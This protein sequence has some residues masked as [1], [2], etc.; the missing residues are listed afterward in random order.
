MLSN[1]DD[2]VERYVAVWNE[3]DPALRR[4]GVSE[5]WADD[6]VYANQ[7]AEFRGHAGIEAAVTEAYEQFVKNGEYVFKTA[8]VD[9]NHEAVRFTWDMVPTAG[10]EP[11]SI[12]TQLFLVGEDGR[13]VHDYQFIDKMPS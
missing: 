10:G 2:F 13:I 11:A 4:K 8:K 9:E 5:I 1:I 7:G 12:G 3:G 6:A